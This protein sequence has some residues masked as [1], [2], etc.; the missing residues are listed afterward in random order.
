MSHECI[1]AGAVTFPPDE[2][3]AD[4]QSQMSEAVQTAASNDD[5]LKENQPQIEWLDGTNGFEVP[6]EHP[7]FEMTSRVIAAVT[8][9]EP[10]VNPLH[11]ASDVRN[12]I[13]QKGIPT[14]GFGPLA[15]DSSQIGG[16]DEWVDVEDYLRAVKV[17]GS[18]ILDWCGA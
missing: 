4:V 9:I 13:L 18:I 17:V 14:V 15:G 16:R 3:M 8:G 2:N 12:P 1:L 6:A 7:L 11:T 10:S 5:W